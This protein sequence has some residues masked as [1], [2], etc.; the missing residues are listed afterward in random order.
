MVTEDTLLL[1]QIEVRRCG[2]AEAT[3]VTDVSAQVAWHCILNRKH[4][5]MLNV[6]TDVTVGLFLHQ[7]AQRSGC[8]YTV[9]TGDEPG[10]CKQLFDFSRAGVRGGLGT[11]QGK[12]N[13]IN[14]YATPETA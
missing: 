4:V 11:G 5:V 12:N 1:P 13:P 9:S 14:Y 6:E 8:V 2:H 7:M 10:V 3:G